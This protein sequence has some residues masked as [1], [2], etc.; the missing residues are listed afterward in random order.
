MHYFHSQS[1]NHICALVNRQGYVLSENSCVYRSSKNEYHIAMKTKIS[2]DS[3]E[4][5]PPMRVLCPWIQK[6]SVSGLSFRRNFTLLVQYSQSCLFN[7]ISEFRNKFPDWE[8]C[9][10]AKADMNPPAFKGYT[11]KRSILFIV[12]LLL[13][14]LAVTEGSKTV[15][16]MQCYPLLI[17]ILLQD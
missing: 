6:V 3:T 16:V 15:L 1:R 14:H 10:R 9:I 2:P 17:L 13:R 7:P 11:S 5:C 8:H 12:K 4:H